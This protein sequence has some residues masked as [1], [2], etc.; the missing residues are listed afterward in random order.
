MHKLLFTTPRSGSN[1]I[2][3]LID[4]DNIGEFFGAPITGAG[5][6][7]KL[8]YLKDNNYP[9]IKIFP[10]SF[11]GSDRIFSFLTEHYHFVCL[12]RLDLKQQILSYIIAE[13]LAKWVY[14]EN[15]LLNI[16]K[17]TIV[18]NMNTF[19][20]LEMLLL[21]F[22]N[23]LSSIP[24]KSFIT[25]EDLLGE[26]SRYKKTP[27]KYDAIDYIYNKQEL[28]SRYFALKKYL[29]PRIQEFYS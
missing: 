23:K 12:R 6:T 19:Y 21:G 11:T 18:C 17:N 26:D 4:K 29:E 5:L 27:Y 8:E 3:D 9:C 13:K 22:Y 10:N 14:T 1:Y 20:K 16:G 25:F 28:L 2:I 7:E 24:N 15:D